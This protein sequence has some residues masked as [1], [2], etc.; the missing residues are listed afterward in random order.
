MELAKNAI[1][2]MG[3]NMTLIFNPVDAGLDVLHVTTKSLS[4]DSLDIVKVGELTHELDYNVALLDGGQVDFIA[5]NSEGETRHYLIDA[6]TGIFE[7]QDYDSSVDGQEAEKFWS[8]VC[9]KSY[10]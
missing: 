5:T 4:Q 9:Q 6:E 7:E 8:K 10:G 3:V 1:I 2:A